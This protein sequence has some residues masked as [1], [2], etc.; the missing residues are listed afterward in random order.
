VYRIDAAYIV[1]DYMRTL[2]I[3]LRGS[4]VNEEID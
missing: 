3:Y 2:V 1:V 4:E